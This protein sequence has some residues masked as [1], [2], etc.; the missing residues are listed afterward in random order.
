MSLVSTTVLVD[1]SPEV[2]FDLAADPA[3][4]PEW[5]ALVT[6]MGEIAGRRGGI[7]SSYVGYYRLAGRRVEGRFVVTAAERPTLLEVAGTTR[8]GWVRWTTIIE[9]AGEGSLLRASLEYELPGEILR[10]VLGVLAG[11]RIDQELKRTYEN[12]K[13]LVEADARTGAPVGI[14]SSPHLETV[15]PRH[16]D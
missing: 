11:S 16:G 8:G 10:S 9:P 12:F 13:R 1:A 15:G 6:E 3:R 2:V 7:G 14:G 4:G 5:Q